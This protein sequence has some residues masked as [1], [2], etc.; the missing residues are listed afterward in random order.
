M[1]RPFCLRT[2]L[3]LETLEDRLVPSTM[4][5]TYPDG[6]WRWDSSAGWSH[7]S[8]VRAGYL[9]VDDAGNVY[10]QT[11]FGNPS[12]GVWRWSAATASWAKLSNL[13]TDQFQVT[14]GGVLYGDFGAQG[15]WRWS[16]S[17][18]MNLS[19][20]NPVF[21]AV[22]DSDAFFGRFDQSGAQGVWRWTPT[23]GWSVLTSSLPLVLQTDSAGDFVG[24]FTA[25]G[26]EGTWRWSPTAGWARLST[27]VPAA[28]IAVSGNGTIFENRGVNG[29][30]Y[31]R[32]GATSFTQFDTDSNYSSAMTALPDGSLY[33]Q[34]YDGTHYN[35]WYWNAN[36][37]GL[38]AGLFRLFQA[39]SRSS[40][41]AIGKDGD[42]FFS[43]DTS[44]SIGTGNWSVSSAYHL[45]GGSNTQRPIILG[46]QR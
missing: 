28:S 40:Y 14:P 43:D 41:P 6:V 21:I 33:V 16:N 1:A 36:L 23:A 24:M 45:L 15:V 25:A 37:L 46:S 2:R 9:E 35:G 18:W 12:D 26:Q 4:A 29:L 3:H 8:N 22:S 11:H 42:L 7:I 10:A 5:G 13:Q 31:A 20:L 17:G 19:G 39:D 34:K 44:G 32:P 27:A 30:W 38:G